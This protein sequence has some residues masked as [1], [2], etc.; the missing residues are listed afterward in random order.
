MTACRKARSTRVRVEFEV[1]TFTICDGWTNTWTI[2]EH[3]AEPKPQVF[4]TR[5]EAAAELDEFFADIADEIRSGE[6]SVEE[7]YSVDE[8]R[9]VKCFQK[10]SAP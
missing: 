9:V 6:R 3:G 1:Q 10:G 8:F 4:T 2:T 7:G 5:E